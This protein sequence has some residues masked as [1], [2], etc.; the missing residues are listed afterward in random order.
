M[1][2]CLALAGKPYCRPDLLPRARHAAAI[3]VTVI[4]FVA[5]SA[6]YLW[7]QLWLVLPLRSTISTH[8]GSWWFAAIF[9][10]L[11]L[12]LLGFPWAT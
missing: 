12:G 4:C 1:S 6:G 8:T 11:M 2:R 5:G 9:G 3:A 10:V 7:A